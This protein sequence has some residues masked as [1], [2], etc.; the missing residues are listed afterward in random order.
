MTEPT[1]HLLRDLLLDDEGDGEKASFRVWCED[2]RPLVYP[3][4]LVTEAFFATC[5]EC[6]EARSRA[7]SA[8]KPEAPKESL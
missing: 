7:A 2:G 3:L 6:L 5:P 1:R 4:D 8:V